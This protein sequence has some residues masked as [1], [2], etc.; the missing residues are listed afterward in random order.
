MQRS[1]HPALIGAITAALLFGIVVP[2]SKTLLIGTGP[3]T[4]A[5]LLYMG[6]GAGLLLLK[7]IRPQQTGQEAPVTRRDIP[8]LAV[9]VFAGSV[10]GPILLMTGLTTVPAGTASL[11]LNAELV[12]TGMIASFFFSEPLG[13]RVGLAMTSV[14]IGGLIL[15][16]DPAGAFGI[17]AGAVLILGACFC[18]G[19][20]NNVTRSL[21][22]KDPASVVIIKGMCA[23]IVGLILA[24]LIGESLPPYQVILYIL[25]TGFFG[26]GLSLV[27]FIRSLRT[28]GA[29][30]TGSLFALA[31]F[32]GAGIS[33]IFLGEVPGYQ[34]F[35]SFLFMAVGVYLIATEDHHHLH[36]HMRINHDHRHRHD[37]GHHTHSHLGL[38]SGDHSHLHQHDLMTHD[39]HH[40]PDLHH[41]HNHESVPDDKNSEKKRD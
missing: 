4:L 14:V 41:Y 37:D 18:W 21:S 24:A 17:S 19:I 30:R 8:Y 36:S 5:A 11:L 28:L 22:G 1:D 15:S 29:V 23:G 40:T 25:I 27:L 6:A 3:I 16:V 20:D 13:R 12:M 31:P 34:V 10:M 39:H 35:V 32:I 26:Y 33:W 38:N 7:I 2:I 9:I